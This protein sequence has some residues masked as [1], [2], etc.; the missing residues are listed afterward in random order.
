MPEKRAYFFQLASI[1]LVVLITLGLGILQLRALGPL[2][3]SVSQTTTQKESSFFV[4][5]ESEIVTVPDEAQVSVGIEA[6]ASTVAQAQAQTNQ[7]IS[8]ITDQLSDL[9]IAKED[10]K[11]TNYNVNPQYD[12]NSG[13]NRITGYMVSSNLRIKVKELDKVNQ[14]IDSATG[15]GANRI[16]GITFTLSEEKE[17]ELVKQARKEAIEDAKEDA[18]E[19]ASLAGMK[20]GRIINVSEDRGGQPMPLM[21]Q[22][23]VSF[24]AMGGAE[25]ATQVE[26]GSTTFKYTVTLSYETL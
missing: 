23:S 16:G 6:Q 5:G 26:P 3:I 9:G 17:E 8:A 19:L 14:V 25:E 21:M 4:T 18:Q 1:A 10:I 15:A 7:V 2:P 20:L 24:D 11:T 22:R 13:T 12:F